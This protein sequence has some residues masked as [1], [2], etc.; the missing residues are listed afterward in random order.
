M[1]TVLLLDDEQSLLKLTALY[2][3]R[4]GHTT[5]PCAS[6]QSALEQFKALNG[7]VDLLIA[8]VSLGRD[9][10]VEFG[11]GLHRW[12]PALKLLFISGYP[13]A[14]WSIRDAALFDALPPALVRVLQKPFSALDLAAKVEELIGPLAG[15]HESKG[16]LQ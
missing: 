15:S 4:G 5:V 8:D 14:A 6:P 3:R 10:G 11:L 13:L 9:S 12:S 16:C 7:G 2:L 1:G